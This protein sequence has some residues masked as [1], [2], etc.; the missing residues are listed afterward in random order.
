MLKKNNS[1]NQNYI[2]TNINIILEHIENDNQLI[3]FV[4]NNNIDI[5]LWKQSLINFFNA[6]NNK[7]NLSNLNQD[8]KN[9]IQDIFG[10]NNKCDKFLYMFNIQHGI[11]GD[12]SIY[13]LN[14]YLEMHQ[15]NIY[16]LLSKGTIYGQKHKKLKLSDLKIGQDYYLEFNLHSF[17]F[18][19]FK[20]IIML[21]QEGPNIRVQRQ[22]VNSTQ[23]QTSTILLNTHL[24]NLNKTE[25]EIRSELS[26]PKYLLWETFRA[27][28]AGGQ[29]V[30]KTSSAVRLRHKILKN[31]NIVSQQERNQIQNRKIALKKF[32][33][34]L[35][36]DIMNLIK[37]I[38][39]S[40]EHNAMRNIKST[41]Y[42]YRRKQIMHED[43]FQQ[44]FHDIKKDLYRE[45]SL[46]RTYKV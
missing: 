6:R 31:I 10:N 37:Q 3:C 34:N 35:S 7:I 4:Q 40:K 46:L 13:F 44:T 25:Y 9:I 22:P 16:S 21:S 12:E 5:V 17:N 29:H 11:G 24:L 18:D 8:E 15:K 28:G 26:Q 1:H 45:N 43:G 27:S 41:T 38:I 42:N 2:S 32:E 14:D 36:L 33:D 30:N 19:M 39:T 23:M 20:T